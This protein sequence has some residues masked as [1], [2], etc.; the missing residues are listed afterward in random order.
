MSISLGQ[1]PER[2]PERSQPRIETAPLV[3]ALL[4]YRL[5]HLLR[6][7]RSH[8]SLRLIELEARRLE[9]EAAEL[10]DTAHVGIEIFDHILVI[11]AQDLPG[12]RLVPMVHELDVVAIIARD[13]IET[14]RELLAGSEQLLEIAEAASHRIAA[15]V[16]DLGLR[17]YQVNESDVAEIVGH[18][19]DKERP[20]GAIDTGV[21]EV[22]LAE[23]RAL[24]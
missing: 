24:L 22:L 21:R 23:P 12:Q 20:A 14:I 13:I 18:L 5:A 8:A 6:A 16:D 1:R 9:L 2:R 19:V 3:E 11:H 10:E 7:R 17:Q 15:R 4:V